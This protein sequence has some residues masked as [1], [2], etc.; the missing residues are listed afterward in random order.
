MDIQ[1][2]LKGKGR[3]KYKT[4]QKIE[5]NQR[6]IKDRAERLGEAERDTHNRGT[7]KRL[8]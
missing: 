3:E 4:D 8:I 6:S 1:G 7:E 5:A 2:F